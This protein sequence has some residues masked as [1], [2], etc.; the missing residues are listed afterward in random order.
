MKVH[1]PQCR[2]PYDVPE[3]K[4]TE[5][6]ITATCR[7]CGAGMIIRRQSGEIRVSQSP[8]HDARETVEST[9]VTP[10]SSESILVQS[11]EDDFSVLAE[12]PAYP[13]NRDTWIVV[14]AAVILA[15]VLVGGYFVLEGAKMPSLKTR[16]NPI[17]SFLSMITGGKVYETC[18]R[19]V[20]QNE[21][22]FRSFGQNVQVSL[23]RQN[24]KSVNGRKTATVLVNAQG[25]KATGQ[26]YFQLR[27]EGDTWRVLTA[28]M[29]IGKGKYER[30]Y[31]RSKSRTGGKI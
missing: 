12:S 17:T 6:G 3:E 29:R 10:A 27:K 23:I 20:D 30:L 31:P 14:A 26:V 9:E 11:D 1:C 24:V 19:F 18:E 28:A 15:L 5:Y 21:G 22:L 13:K 8:P 7:K 16:W 4:I 25:T 2:T